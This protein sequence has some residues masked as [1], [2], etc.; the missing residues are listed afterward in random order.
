MENQGFS[1]L[2]SEVSQFCQ[3]LADKQFRNI[4]NQLTRNKWEDLLPKIDEL[5]KNANAN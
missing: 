1:E 5:R 2:V 3:D 4:D